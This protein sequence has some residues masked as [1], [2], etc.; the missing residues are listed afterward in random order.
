M[1]RFATKCRAA[2]TFQTLPAGAQSLTGSPVVRTILRSPRIQPKLTVGAVDDPAER[3]A[4]QV[5]GQVMRM[6]DRDITASEAGAPSI[7]SRDGGILRLCA[8]C[9]KEQGGTIQRLAT[10]K[11]TPDAA[12]PS[13]RDVLRSPGR[14][15]DAG[16]RAF[17]EPRFGQNFGDV[18][19]HTGP[20]AAESARSLQALAYTSGRNVVF[21]AGQYAPETDSG[22]HVL[23]HELTHVVQQNAHAADPKAVNRLADPETSSIVRRSPS[24]Q[25]A[26]TPPYLEATELNECIRIMGEENATY[27]RETVLGEPPGPWVAPSITA[28]L[29]ITLENIGSVP[30]SNVVEATIRQAYEPIAKAAGRELKF[31]RLGP[32]DLS[33]EFDAGGRGKT[34][35]G[36]MILGIDGGAVVFVGAHEDLRVCNEPQ[37]DP[38]TSPTLDHTSALEHVFDKGEVEFGQ[39]VGTTAVHELGHIMAKLPHTADPHNVMFAAG[40]DGANLPKDQRTLQSMRR[41][42]SEQ[43]SFSADQT[44]LLQEAIRTGQFTGGMTTTSGAPTP[45]IS[46]KRP[47]VPTTPTAPKPPRKP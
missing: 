10:G 40:P 28:P 1:Q 19:V 25:P 17:M 6:P 9:E 37:G 44:A 34:P 7:G 46:P 27:C 12:P 2:P 30:R 36:D 8:D 45:P 29:I 47:R 22:R 23:A 38:T 43:K 16:A 20:K 39:F 21:G 14:P 24:P 33:L 13:V 4:D 18:R 35:C 42:W 41:H 26:A 15:L 31:N 3:E 32:G 5:A 11:D